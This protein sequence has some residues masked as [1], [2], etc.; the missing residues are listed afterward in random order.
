VTLLAVALVG[1]ICLILFG[2]SIWIAGLGGGKVQPAHQETIT[3][4]A[5]P[6]VIAFAKRHDLGSITTNDE[7]VRLIER[8]GLQKPWMI[9]LTQWQQGGVITHISTIIRL[10]EFDHLFPINVACLQAIAGRPPE[11]Y[12]NTRIVAVPEHLLETEPKQALAELLAR[13]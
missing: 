5:M 4:Y 1:G 12:A 7:L 8:D 3:I 13:H 2:R 11:V 10:G 9:T 6:T